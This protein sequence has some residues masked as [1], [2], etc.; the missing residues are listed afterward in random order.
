MTLTVD[1]VLF[2]WPDH[3]EV[4]TA[5]ES[6]GLNPTFGGVHDG[7]ETQNSLIAFPDGSYL[8][9]MTPT[10]PGTEPDRWAGIVD[11]WRGPE[12]WC[13]RADVR[14]LLSHTI[15]A[16]A[17][18]D[19][20]HPGNRD[21]PDGTRVEWVTGSYGPPELRGVLPFA[22][23]D[24]T[25]QHFRIP[26]TAV[27][28]A[29]LTGVAEVVVGVESIAAASEWFQRLHNCPTPVTVA[30]P[31]TADAV[32][33]PG[34]SVSLVDPASGSTLADRLAE[35]D[36]QPL[37]FLLATEDFEAAAERFAL[38]STEEWDDRRVAWFDADLFH[39]T[40]GVLEA[41]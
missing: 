35:T 14:D 6:V 20:P 4:L 26:E 25:P 30:T 31:L 24:R 32:T 9:F 22:I 18:V 2:A 19:G 39:D 16:G 28:D 3:N 36:Q 34:Q 11:H 5:C 33:I 40:V 10:D 1:H 15:A 37:A 41:P 27:T 13:I 8:E 7:G 23:A 21:R 38:T 17:P 12:N 29:P